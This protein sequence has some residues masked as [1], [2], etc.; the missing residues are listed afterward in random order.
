MDKMFLISINKNFNKFNK[1]LLIFMP[2]QILFL[3][4]IIIFNKYI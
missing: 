4:I 3:L 1:V 2:I